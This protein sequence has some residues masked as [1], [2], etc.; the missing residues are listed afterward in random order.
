MHSIPIKHLTFGHLSLLWVL[1]SGTQKQIPKSGQISTEKAQATSQQAAAAR[2]GSIHNSALPGIYE[3]GA[4]L[5]S[6]LQP[7][8]SQ[9]K[10]RRLS[11]PLFPLNTGVHLI[12]EILG[13][14]Q[15]CSQSINPWLLESRSHGLMAGVLTLAMNVFYGFN[16]YFFLF[17]KYFGFEPFLAR[18]SKAVKLR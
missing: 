1:D 4:G 7:S 14:K 13:F 11:L 18:G 12:M 9:H 10:G 6:M 16:K 17:L 3:E 15:N 8:L 2:P 5:H